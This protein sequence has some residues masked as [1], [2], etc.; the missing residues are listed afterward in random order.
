[1]SYLNVVTTQTAEYSARRSELS[2]R[3][4]QFTATVALLRALGS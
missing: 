2:L 3:A 1:M 4:Q